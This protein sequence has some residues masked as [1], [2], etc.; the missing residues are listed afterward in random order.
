MKEA[1]PPLNVVLLG[2]PGAGK[3]TQ[4]NLLLARRRMYDLDMGEILRKRRSRALRAAMDSGKVAPTS[5]VREIFKREIL[6]VPDGLGILFNGTPKMLGEAK[7][8]L[9]LLNQNGRTKDRVLVLYLWVPRSTIFER[10]RGRGRTDDTPTA[11]ANRFRYYRKNIAGVVSY[12]K[13]QYKFVKV[14]GT[15]TVAEAAMNE[16]NRTFMHSKASVKT[17]QDIAL[18]AEG[19]TI[20]NKILRDTAKRAVP[21]ISTWE[22]NEFAEAQIVAAGGR[23]A[24]KGVGDD[25][26][27][28]FPAGLCTSVNDVVVHGIPSKR[29]ILHDGDIVGLDIGMEYKGRYTDTATTVAVGKVSKEVQELLDVTQHAL[30]L[31]I[32]Q[33][34]EGNTTGDIGNAIQQYVERHGFSIVRD[35]VGHGVGYTVHEDPQVPNYGHPGTGTKLEAGVVIAIEPMVNAGRYAVAFADDGWSILTEDGSLSAHFEH[36]VA[37]GKRAPKI[38]T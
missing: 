25:P 26:D 8:V 7:L 4:A 24:F 29:E 19:G 16:F 3:A 6:S 13:V 1:L 10:T 11:L 38:L 27:N 23:P 37:V 36:T 32:Q 12:L 18:I 28:L 31:G 33:A 22:L 34:V 15:G 2:D 5:L 30:A 35:L 9:K 17:E 21:G 20:I 14:S